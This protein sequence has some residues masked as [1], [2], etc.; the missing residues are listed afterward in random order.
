MKVEMIYIHARRI[1]MVIN[2]EKYNFSKDNEKNWT[3]KNW[4]GQNLSY[5]LKDTCLENAIKYTL[6][7]CHS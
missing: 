2:G 3:V 7:L 5:I 1:V 6:E 4:Q